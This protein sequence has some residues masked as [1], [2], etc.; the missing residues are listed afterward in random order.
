MDDSQLSRHRQNGSFASRISKLRGCRAYK[1]HNGSGVDN[2]SLGLVV[3]A[4]GDNGV[5]TAE[6]DALDVDSLR[7]VPD[8]LGGIDGIRVIGM[9]YA[10][11]VKDDVDAAP[12]IEVVDEGL[13]VDFFGNVANFGFNLVGGGN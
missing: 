10:S 5:L 9:H 4:Q 11:V 13:D 7:Q 8:L 2:G 12:G 3:L 1:G 6:P